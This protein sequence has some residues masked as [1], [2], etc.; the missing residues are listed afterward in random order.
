MHLCP[1]NVR[2]V[3]SCRQKKCTPLNVPR[4]LPYS[5]IPSRLHVSLERP[6]TQNNQHNQDIYVFLLQAETLDGNSVAIKTLLLRGRTSWEPLE[7]LQRKAATLRG[8]SHPGIPAYLDYFEEDTEKDVGF[9][10]VQVLSAT[11]IPKFQQP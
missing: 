2:A 6:G 10:L 8:L 3:L 4:Q 1:V 11:S 7:L 9:F 5:N